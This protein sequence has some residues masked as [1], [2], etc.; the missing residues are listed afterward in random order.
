MRERRC[1]P[2][3]TAASTIVW[4]RLRP[5]AGLSMI[6]PVPKCVLCQGEV[7]RGVPE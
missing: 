7:V 2:G 3:L 1:F 6:R 4:L 5:G